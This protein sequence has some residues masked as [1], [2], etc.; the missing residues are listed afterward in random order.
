MQLLE[1]LHVVQNQ[2]RVVS[3]FKF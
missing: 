1:G 3:G 2:T